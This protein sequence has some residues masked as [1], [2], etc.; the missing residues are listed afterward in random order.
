MQSM[1][2]SIETNDQLHK[3]IFE[4]NSLLNKFIYSCSHDLKGPLSSIKGLVHLAERSPHDKVGECL[5]Q[6]TESVNRMNHCLTSLEALMSN[7][8]EPVTQAE[9][10]FMGMINELVEEQMDEVKSKKIKLSVRVL[11]EKMVIS[12]SARLRLIIEHLLQNAITFQ[13]N[14]RATKLIDISVKVL[15]DHVDIEICDNGEGIHK[16]RIADIFKIFY[17]GSETSKG[18]G[19]GLYIVKETVEKLNGLIAVASSKGVGSNFAVKIPI[20]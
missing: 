12:D 19:L 11:S 9:V 7:S 5:N 6:I 1:F 10:D 16:D 3:E 4:K 15:N 8:W 14:S 20:P 13:K 17:R 2:R 18:S